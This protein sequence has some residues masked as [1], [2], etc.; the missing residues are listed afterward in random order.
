MPPSASG[1]TTVDVI[2]RDGQEHHFLQVKNCKLYMGLSLVPVEFILPVSL[3]L[4]IVKVL[5][6]LCLYPQA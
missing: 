3:D 1:E 4:M 5:Q 2:L 6:H